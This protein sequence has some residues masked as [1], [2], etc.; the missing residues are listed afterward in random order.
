VR[1]QK[2]TLRCVKM[3]PLRA[4]MPKALPSCF[5]R[6][7]TV[8]MLRLR[9]SQ[10]SQV[11]VNSIHMSS[12]SW[13]PSAVMFV[14]SCSSSPVGHSDP[15]LDSVKVSDTENVPECVGVGGGVTVADTVRE[16]VAL[17]VTLGETLIDPDSV[18]VE[19][20]VSE[21]VG[22]AVGVMAIV[23]ERDVD[24]L[25]VAS[26][27]VTVSDS[28][29]VSVTLRVSVRL[30]GSESETVTSRDVV[31]L[32]VS[33]SVV[34]VE[35]ESDSDC[36]KDPLSDSS[37]VSV[38]ESDSD[39]VSVRVPVSGGVMVMDFVS[40]S[41]VVRENVGGGVTVNVAVRVG[42]GVT[43]HEIVSVVETVLVRVGGGVT[44]VDSETEALTDGVIVRGSVRVVLVEKVRVEESVSDHD[45]VREAAEIVPV[46]RDLERDRV[47]PPDP[48]NESVTVTA[49]ESVM[50]GETLCVTES[51]PT[52]RDD[53]G[54]I[55]FDSD[56]R[57]E[58]DIDTVSDGDGSCDSE[59]VNEVDASK[60]PVLALSEPVAVGGSVR[61]L[62][63][64]G[65]MI[66]YGPSRMHKSAAAAVSHL[67]AA[68][69]PSGLATTQSP[70]L[71][72]GSRP[73]HFVYAGTSSETYANCSSPPMLRR[74]IPTSGFPNR[75]VNGAA[76][77]ATVTSSAVGGSTSAPPSALQVS[78]APPNGY[79]A[80]GVNRVP[81]GTDT[82]C[83]A[84]STSMLIPWGWGFVH[85][86]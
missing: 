65:Q 33:V 11:S 10:L 64:G 52:E 55:S 44:V 85:T 15:E 77:S 39:N 16:S 12:P 1:L 60:V 56:S 74:V 61:V 76:D 59:L 80:G 51:E 20:A 84:D 68:Y 9:H 37:C 19:S 86:T 4:P 2:T 82:K 62:D 23:G 25:P 49:V 50:S 45:A 58:S 32:S 27:T 54:E 5:E 17:S 81:K 63:C 34:E 38:D 8:A 35:R 46:R 43:V 47:K 79:D 83:R 73:D 53:D 78:T 31:E 69:V 57:R 3:F 71:S 22:S 7:T 29:K 70:A 41:V 48:E 13:I 42:G 24:P 18:A 30:I 21:G 75:R 67:T 26:D 36:V 28:P 6:M 40:V 72:P 14:A 66:G